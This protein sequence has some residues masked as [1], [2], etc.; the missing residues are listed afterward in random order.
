MNTRLYG[1]TY[2]AD[3]PIHGTLPALVRTDVRSGRTVVWVPS[4]NNTIKSSE[5]FEL[6][7][8]QCKEFVPGRKIKAEAAYIALKNPDLHISECD[9]RCL[10]GKRSCDCRCGGACHGR[11]TCNPAIH[12]L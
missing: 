6:V 5:N 12:L 11:G 2:W 7:C 9:G 8:P 3:C 10:T 1:E 4:E